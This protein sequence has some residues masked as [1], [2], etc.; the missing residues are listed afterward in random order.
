[1]KPGLGALSVLL[2]ALACSRA[3]EQGDCPPG[4]GAR[5][6]DTPLLAFLSRARAAHHAADR[7]EQS[8]ELERAKT[9]LLALTDG[10]VPGGKTPPVEAREVLADTRARL[11]DLESRIGDFARA[12]VE[13]RLGLELVPETSYFRGHLLEVQG[14]MEERRAKRLAAQGKDDAANQANQRAVEAF[15][16]AMTIQAEVIR[17]AVDAGAPAA[18][19]AE[20]ARPARRE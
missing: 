3:P 15:E 16:H 17:G 18:R 20:P 1:V 14:L 9:S 13:L 12:E 4:S 8:G 2:L 10:P 5:P 7:A 6:V 11:A 19:P